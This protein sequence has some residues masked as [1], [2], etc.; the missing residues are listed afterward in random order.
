MEDIYRAKTL[1]I[2]GVL[3]GLDS[4]LE[5]AEIVVTESFLDAYFKE[6]PY[7]A[8]DNASIDWTSDMARTVLSNVPAAAAACR[9]LIEP[10][11]ATQ[12]CLLCETALEH[13]DDITKF[14]VSLRSEVAQ[15]LESQRA[16]LTAFYGE[17]GRI[18]SSDVSWF[19]DNLVLEVADV[20]IRQIPI[21][22]IFT[23]AEGEEVSRAATAIALLATDIR[24][25]ISWGMVQNWEWFKNDLVALALQLINIEGLLGNSPMDVDISAVLD[26]KNLSQRER[27][28]TEQPL[29]L[30]LLIDRLE[31]KQEEKEEEK[32]EQ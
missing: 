10:T 13:L 1:A 2:Q 26:S 5:E 3:S 28:L 27:F 23:D 9:F 32:S 19:S 14:K 21:G 15:Y 24:A 4:A 12:I 16:I 20:M 18:S 22:L 31:E 8:I 25:Q 11:F 6:E 29:R 17:A 30:R 7:P